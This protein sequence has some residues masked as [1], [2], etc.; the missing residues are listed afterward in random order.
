MAQ[1]GGQ[2]ELMRICDDAL[3]EWKRKEPG[4]RRSATVTVYGVR[5][6]HVPRGESVLLLIVMSTFY[7]L[8]R[9]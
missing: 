5:T 4:K 8:S 7:T 9:S 3:I 6:S 2:N 1:A